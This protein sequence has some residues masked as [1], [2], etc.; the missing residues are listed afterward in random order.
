[1]MGLLEDAIR[2]N[3]LTNGLN[4]EEICLLAA[5]GVE[6]S[7]PAGEVIVRQFDRE[8]DLFM[9][10]DGKVAINA[11]NG[12]LVARIKPGGVFGEIA[13][14]D[15]RPRSAT[16]MAET[17]VKLV[18]FSA[19]NIRALLD[20]HCHISTVILRNIGRVLCER[21]RSANLQIEALLLATGVD[22]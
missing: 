1:M 9:V 17:D 3:Y 7:Y 20:N 19:E 4:E 6:V 14:L 12:D 22:I 13:L 16:V 10:L 5:N 2:G 21:L 8:A 11:S 18:K 15:D